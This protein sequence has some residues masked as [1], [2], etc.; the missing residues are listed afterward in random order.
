MERYENLGG[1]SGIAGYECGNDFIRVFFKDDSIYLFNSRRP[2]FY[3]VEK[4]IKL[5]QRGEGLNAFIN[6]TIG[7]KFAKKER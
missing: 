1:D 5:A 6:T 7:K 4:M 3:P 2:G